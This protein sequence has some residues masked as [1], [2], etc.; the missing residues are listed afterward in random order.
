MSW[1]GRT[2]GLT[3]AVRYYYWKP[4]QAFFR[5]FELQEYSKA[6]VRL[7]HPIASLGCDD[8]IFSI[9]LKEMGVLDNVDFHLDINITA[10]GKIISRGENNCVASDVRRLPFKDNSLSSALA[11]NLL[12]SIPTNSEKDLDAVL[13][14]V[15]RSLKNEGLFILTVPTS[16]FNKNLLVLRFIQKLRFK[17]IEDYYI[18]NLNKRA[19]HYMILD[20]G[21]W[22]EKL[23]KYNLN[24]EK[25]QHYFTKHQ[26]AWYSILVVSI[27]RILGVT[28][29]VK[30]RWLK[31]KLADLI[32][33]FFR[34]VFIV[35]QLV[36]DSHKKDTAG[37][38]LIVARKIKVEN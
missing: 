15:Y 2:T 6:D 36:E 14:E 25:A 12:S 18:N 10:L 20:E 5:S 17:F 11:N 8:D 29:L 13:I 22:L 33:L 34:R 21:L 26:G 28:E 38:V 7:Y 30:N 23:R 19:A 27:F 35:E 16:Y 32:A 37:Y 24:P 31:E 1:V 4:S 9:M 3:V